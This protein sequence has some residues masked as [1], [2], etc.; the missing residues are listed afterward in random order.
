MRDAVAYVRALPGV[1]GERVG[2]VGFSLGGFLALSA[3][4]QEDLKIAA[5]VDF[6]GGLP[7]EQRARVKKLPPALVIHGTRD[8]VVPVKEAEALRD[9]FA[10][11]RLEGEVKVY[12]DVGNMF[13]DE[14]GNVT[15]TALMAMADA[16]ARTTAHLEKCLKGGTAVAA[17][18]KPG[19]I[20]ERPIPAQRER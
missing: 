16:K 3:A 15:L 4:A 12:P 9:L 5:V 17:E 19:V 8:D 18:P 14:K 10:A 11:K 6:F 13:L 2:L 1:D 7:E 20:A